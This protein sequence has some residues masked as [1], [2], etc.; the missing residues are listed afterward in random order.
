MPPAAIFADFEEI[1]FAGPVLFATYGPSDAPPNCVTQA[2]RQLQIGGC[3]R[4]TGGIHTAIGDPNPGVPKLL[5]LWYTNAPTA[6]YEDGQD[7]TLPGVVLY[8]TYNPEWEPS[9]DVTAS[10][11]RLQSVGQNCF[12]GGIHLAIGD[13][14][15]GVPKKFRVWTA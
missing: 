12:V 8:A 7:G 10:V 5:K 2:I 1:A 11:V 4:I 15:P 9:H 3:N 6:T 14:R 13:P